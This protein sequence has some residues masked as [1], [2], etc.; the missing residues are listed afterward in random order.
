ML[1]I[2]EPES[3]ASSDTHICHTALGSQR[4]IW[5]KAVCNFQFLQK[6]TFILRPH[7][8]I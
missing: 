1:L 5:N 2:L 4:D 8:N 3:G 7:Y 6:I